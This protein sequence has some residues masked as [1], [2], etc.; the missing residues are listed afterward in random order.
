MTSK[1]W[2][3]QNFVMMSKHI[4]MSKSSLWHQKCRHH[5]KNMLWWQKVHCFKMIIMIRHDVKS[6]S[7]RQKFVMKSKVCHEIKICYYVNDVK[8]F[9][10]TSKVLHG[11]QSMSCR[12]NLPWRQ[13]VR[14]DVK[15]CCICYDI[16]KLVTSKIRH[17]VINTSWCPNARHYAKKNYNARNTSWRQK[18]RPDVKIIVMM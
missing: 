6:L 9:V 8:K 15:R 1:N 17:D 7:W 11:V 12:Q 5:V 13:N 10:M 16:K 18:V 2:L 3:H 14:H 4:M